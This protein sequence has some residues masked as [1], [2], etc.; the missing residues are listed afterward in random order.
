METHTT[1]RVHYVVP[2]AAK[3]CGGT[4]LLALS[5]C[6]SA[7]AHDSDT[8][9]FYAFGEGEADT[10]VNGVTVSNAVNEAY[11]GTMDLGTAPSDS[12]LFRADAPGP[13][14]FDAF[15]Y[16]A[17]MVCTNPQSLFFAGGCSDG[18]QVLSFPD[19]ATAVSSNDDYTVEFFVKMDPA[20]S[21]IT[22]WTPM[23][24]MECGMLYNPRPTAPDTEKAYAGTAQ[25]TRVLFTGD[26]G[27]KLYTAVRNATQHSILTT[28]SVLEGGSHCDGYWHH[29][30]MVYKSSNRKMYHY[31]DYGLVAGS[32]VTTNSVLDVSKP[33]LLGNGGFRG[34]V[35]C[36]RVSK[37]ARDKNSFLRCSTSPKLMPETVFHWR[38]D[39]ENG[40][41]VQTVTNTSEQEP[42]FTGQ[43]T[44][45][46]AASYDGHGTVTTWTN[47]QDVVVRPAYTNDV[48]R[49]G[50]V[51]MYG[52]KALGR[53]GGSARLIAKTRTTEPYS[54]GG[55][56]LVL[57]GGDHYPVDSGSFTMEAWM[58][59]DYETWKRKIVDTG[60]NPSLRRLTLFGL[61]RPSTS[62]LFD[63]VLGLWCRPNDDP[64]PEG[65][66]LNILAYDQSSAN[67]GNG[68]QTSGQH[69]E[70]GLLFDGKWHHFAVVY[71]DPSQTF[72]V[73]LDGELKC[74]NEMA[75]PFRPHDATQRYVVGGECSNSAFEGLVDEVRLVRRALEPSEFLKFR[76]P[77]VISFR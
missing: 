21:K 40:D 43:Y 42:V 67:S 20:D 54:V 48:R 65:F 30:A 61:S 24:K 12:V 36:L 47:D 28:S 34:L 59:F 31:L 1:D 6:P 33:V 64:D 73:Y 68:L 35:S 44:G 14:V 63:W 76:S 52:D 50:G 71:D 77:T 25:M 16:G 27:E 29:Y 66:S 3:L 55:T 2:F 7:F 56:Y 11:S 58:K 9:A 5:F 18:N 39:G 46:L 4:L 13:Y 53:N 10:P 60:T 22:S 49:R 41:E 38:L 69:Y 17:D 51:I 19:L 57:P 26:E 32:Y 75:T 72:K 23:L 15:E 45:H 74:S 70:D 37:T 62:Y 8:L